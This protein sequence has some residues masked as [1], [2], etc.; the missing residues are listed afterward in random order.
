MAPSHLSRSSK[1]PSGRYLSPEE[2]EEIALLRAQGIGVREVA[3]R[4]ETSR[5]DCIAGAAAQCGDAGRQP[6]LP[7]DDRAMARGAGG[8]TAEAGEADH[9]PGTANLCAGPAVRFRGCSGWRRGAWPE[10]GAIPNLR[11]SVRHRLLRRH[12]SILSTVEASGKPGAVQPRGIA[13]GADTWLLQ[14]KWPADGGARATAR[15]RRRSAWQRPSRGLKHLAHAS[16][17]HSQTVTYHNHVIFCQRGSTAGSPA[18]RSR[19]IARTR[20]TS[21]HDRS[22]GCRRSWRNPGASPAGPV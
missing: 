13:K 12:R 9:T 22:A 20:P 6:G 2:Q 10:N 16:P 5:V 4:L 7:G 1:S 3:R 15:V 18:A 17:N 19:P 11:R 8:T 21:A 14:I